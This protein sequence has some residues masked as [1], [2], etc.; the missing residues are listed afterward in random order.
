MWE[1]GVV[2]VGIT[3]EAIPGS[4]HRGYV[5]DIDTAQVMGGM[6]IMGGLGASGWRA[7]D[8]KSRILDG[9]KEC[10]IKYFL[11]LMEGGKEE[12]VQEKEWRGMVAA[13]E[14]EI[15]GRV[16]AL[17]EEG[18]QGEEERE[19][20]GEVMEDLM[21]E[22]ADLVVNAEAMVAF[23]HEGFDGARLMKPWRGGGEAR[24][25]CSRTR[26]CMH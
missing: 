16:G 21:E 6:Q 19:W 26:G 20:A 13:M 22:V 10:H 9:H 8:R 5:V 14:E 3:N 17:G 23:K 1:R 4:D 15:E 18:I 12:G 11:E 25:W 7:G 2:Q 24:R